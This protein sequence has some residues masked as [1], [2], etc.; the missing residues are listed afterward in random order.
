MEG[1]RAG[2][3]PA[4]TTGSAAGLRRLQTVENPGCG[5]WRG[6]GQTRTGLGRPGRPSLTTCLLCPL[7]ELQRPARPPSA[8]SRCPRDTR[9]AVG[10]R[11][12]A[13]LYI[14][15]R[16]APLNPCPP[17]MPCPRASFPVLG[18]GVVTWLLTTLDSD[19]ELCSHRTVTDGIGSRQLLDASRTPHFS[20]KPFL[21]RA[22]APQGGPK[23]PDPHG[24]PGACPWSPD[25]SSEGSLPPLSP[26]AAPD[27]ATW[28][29]LSLSVCPSP[30]PDRGQAQREERRPGPLRRLRDEHGARHAAGAPARVCGRDGVNSVQAGGRENTPQG[31]R[32][33][34]APPGDRGLCACAQAPH[35]VQARVTGPHTA[36]SAEH[37]PEG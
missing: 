16:D 29:T 9:A 18:I 25:S 2:A 3:P 22:A 14:L 31:G 36:L 7:C 15:Q 37:R 24:V 21:V 12:T 13:R 8:C 34:G 19:L 10:P 1:H 30:G 28:V 5:G 17:R 33:R 23:A 20:L 27:N 6:R 32:W 26:G 35:R 4:T 11:R